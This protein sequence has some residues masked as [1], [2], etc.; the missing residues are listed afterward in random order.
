MTAVNPASRPANLSSARVGVPAS[1][2]AEPQQFLSAPAT[3]QYLK[4]SPIRLRGL[5][6]GRQYEFSSSRPAQPVDHRDLPGF[7]RT[8]FFRQR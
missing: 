8:G 5:V 4:N 6:T 1:R 2:T 7:L 3:L